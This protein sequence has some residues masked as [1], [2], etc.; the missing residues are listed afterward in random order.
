M[1]LHSF[2]RKSGTAAGLFKSPAAFTAAPEREEEFTSEVFEMDSIR[3]ERWLSVKEVSALIGFEEDT[4]RRRARRNEFR[5]LALPQI[6]RN[7]RKQ[8]P[9]VRMRI[10]ESSV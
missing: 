5:V 7:G 9:H 3:P 4:V 10:S 1:A 6:P 8:H 2:A